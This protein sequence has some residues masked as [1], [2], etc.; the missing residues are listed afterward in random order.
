MNT[1]TIS[2]SDLVADR[3]LTSISE[4][5]RFLM[6]VTPCNVEEAREDYLK[7]TAA[8]HSPRFRYRDLEDLPEVIRARLS[9][10]HPLEVEDPTL[11]HL[12]EAKR[13]ELELQVTMLETRDTPDF[14]ALSMELYGGVTPAL[15]E[16][17]GELLGQLPRKRS[18]RGRCLPATSFARQA[19][20]EIRR[21]QESAPE[22][23]MAIQIRPDTSG[24]MVANGD[25][26][27]AENA[28]V[29][30][31]RLQ[32]LL[33]HEVGTHVLTYFNGSCQPLKLMSA[34]LAGYEETQEGLALMAEGVV[35]GLRADRLRQIAARVIAV[36]R[37]IQGEPFG[38]IHSELVE[39]HGYS[40]SGAF[41][42]AMRVWRSGGLTKDACYL[43]G[44][45]DLVSFVAEGKSLAPLWAGKMSLVDL[46]LV[47]D[48]T[49]R[50]ILSPPTVLPRFFQDPTAMGRLDAIAGSTGLQQLIGVQP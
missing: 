11:A 14:L 21:Y 15:E 7:S 1:G 32:G 38:R 50:R 39:E 28:T 42:I 40:P 18:A 22:L 36:R 19:D 34:G 27:I 12:F 25:L 31:S 45:Q 26:L 30:G 41:T 24:I 20:R 33:A 2:S 8:D 13:R 16:Q 43:R 23:S 10:I 35:D 17:A 47:E 3:E 5:F 49:G 46:P 6:D 9:T 48:L 37:L 44:L 4:S 29:A